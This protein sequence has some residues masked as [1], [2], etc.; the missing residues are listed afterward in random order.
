[1]P[2]A[3]E[4]ILSQLS[5]D[6]RNVSMASEVVVAELRKMTEVIDT[7]GVQRRTKGTSLWG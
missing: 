1:M 3:H 7:C 6:E 4:K 2:T 5:P